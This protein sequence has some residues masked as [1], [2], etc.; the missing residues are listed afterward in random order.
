M[1]NEVR[2]KGLMIAIEFGP[3]KSIKLKMGWSLLHKLDQSL[4]CQ[5]ILI[6]LLT[7]H[8]VLAQVAGHHMDVIKLIP[9]LVLSEQDVE[10]LI[11]AFDTVIGA[12][13]QFPGPVWEVGKRLT[14]HAVKKKS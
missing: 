11:Q 9:P 6:P 5:A 14:Q 12:C 8:H 4:F 1:I 2:G 10:E 13:H 7:D 3:P